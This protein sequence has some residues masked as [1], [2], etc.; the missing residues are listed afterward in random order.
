M[1]RLLLVFV[2]IL[3]SSCSLDNKTG[4]WKDVSDIPIENQ[5]TK[6]INDNKPGSRYED[7]FTKNETFNEEKKSLKPLNVEINNPIR[8][9]N[10]FEKYAIPTNN[11]PNFFYKG[12]KKL[13]FKSSKLSKHLTNDNYLNKNI[14]FYKNNL[15]S[16]NHKGEIFA[17]SLVLKKKIFKYNFYKKNFKKFKKSIDLIINKNI[18]YA[19]DNLGY[20]YALNLDNNTI[21]WAKN[22]GIPF[23]SNL[24]F[25]D[26]QIFVSNQDNVIYSID[27]TTGNINWQFAT[28][29]TF[30]KSDFKN[31][32]ALDP[33]NNNLFFLNTSGELYSINYRTQ[34][35]NWVLN[36]KNLA[37]VGETG[38]FLSQPIVIK[39]N[40]LIV[41]TEETLLNYD[42]LTAQRRWALSANPI[43]KPIITADYTYVILEN[44]LLICL[45]NISGDVAWSKNIIKNI[46]NKKIKRNFNKIIDFKIVN[47]E[48]NIY[49]KTGYL[50]SFN[51]SNGKL[52]HQSRI[53][54][55]GI[56]SEIVFLNGNMFF[57]DRK[58]RLLKFN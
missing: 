34:K 42:M 58:N 38:L 23:R 51:L 53:S 28:G 46:K 24:K 44:D 57:I 10:W 36:F 35:F 17:Y 8:I 18:L 26:N 5:E 45:D 37:L 41:S 12:N 52:N 22:Y 14:I 1:K 21:V 40:N 43:F 49:S 31:N 16:H 2:T 30:L 39:N 25:S 47:S 19:A 3:F 56:N 4:I 54:K 13:L 11:S 33:I 50:L 6:S 20:L 48:I 27:A 32:F 9:A 7:I 29:P 55:S 15:I